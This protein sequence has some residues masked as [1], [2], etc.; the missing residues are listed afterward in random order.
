MSIQSI[1]GKTLKQMIL[2]AASQLEANKDTVNA[3]NVFPVPDGDTGTNMSMTLSSAT[4][5]VERSG[6]R[7]VGEVAAAVAQGSLMG[8]RGNSG[9]I[10]SQLFRGFAKHLDGKVTIDGRDLARAFQEG[11]DTAYKAVMKPVEG[12]ILTVARES[13]AAAVQAT[14]REDDPVRIMKIV[15]EAA[16]ASLARTPELLPVLK[17]AGVVD[18]GGKGL[19][20]ILHGYY[21]ALSGEAVVVSPVTTREAVPAAKHDVSPAAKIDFKVDAEISDIKYPYDCEFF[22]RRYKDGEPIPMEF[23][24]REL[25]QYGDSVYV[26]GSEDFSKVHVHASNPGPVLSLCIQYGDLVDI[27]IHNM[28]EQHEDLLQH[29]QRT[30]GGTAAPTPAAAAM[31]QPEPDQPTAVVAVAV[32]EGMEA[33]FRSL[34]V[35]AVIQ[36]GQTMNPSTQDLLD[37]IESCPSQQVFVLP[38]NKN[39]ILAAEQAAAL[40]EKRVYVIPTRSVP[41]GIAAMVSWMPDEEDGDKLQKAMNRGME[42]VQ[43]GEITFSVRDTVYGELEIKEGDILGLLNGKIQL[44]GQSPEKVLTELLAAM[45]AEHGGEVISIYYGEGV[46]EARAEAVAEELRAQF[47]EHEIEVQYGGQPLY[48]YVFSL[49]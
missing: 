15:V 23:V 7:T 14:R 4:R 33:I 43:T 41:Q 32:G 29:A 17:K 16:E 48:F 11:V 47:P 20:V 30:E 38:N 2:H 5:E 24:A 6:D 19:T 44:T 45:V 1:D 31:E 39:I 27:V 3:L 10:L 8:A 49:E 28:R 36:G 9:V 21:E 18:S 25:E 22:I 40:T 46:E 37:A 12:T 13:A 42:A 34:G 26:V 35:F